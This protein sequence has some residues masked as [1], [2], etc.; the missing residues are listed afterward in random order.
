MSSI[1]IML[2]CVE[3]Y[4]LT[5]V[6]FLFENLDLLD[7]VLS[8][9]GQE[10]R[11][12][13]KKKVKSFLER[14]VLGD[15]DLHAEYRHAAGCD[16]GRMYSSGIQGI[17]RA[18]RGYLLCSSPVIDVDMVNAHPCILYYLCRRFGIQRVPHL[19]LYVE[20]R[21]KVCAEHF[22]EELAAQGKDHVKR[23]FLIA[24]NMDE[25]IN[26]K[27]TFLRG[28]MDDM[29]KIRGVLIKLPEF[30]HIAAD[31]KKKKSSSYPNLN[32]S[33]INRILCKYEHDI[34]GE[35]RKSSKRRKFV[36]PWINRWCWNGSRTTWQ[37][38]RS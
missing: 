3:T 18:V 28:Y 12:V 11:I 37:T 36:S 2:S 31:A 1:D 21:Q 22:P 32:G 34:I 35:M 27:S 23:L 7:P 13:Q 38:F 14:I 15:G 6:G 24:T 30:K 26:H 19:K 33:I 4:D 5:R 20:N 17:M 8:K 16:Y 25:R 10:D 29:E 9:L